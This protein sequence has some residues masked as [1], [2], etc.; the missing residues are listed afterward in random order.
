MLEA[1]RE[2]RECA[3]QRR[4]LVSGTGGVLSRCAVIAREY[5]IPAVVGTGRATRIFCDG[6]LLEI[7]TL[8][9]C[10]VGLIRLR[11]PDFIFRQ[12]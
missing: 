2:I 7:D 1:G 6:Q 12:V 5:G 11:R 4:G 9:Q 3:R 8:A 10:K